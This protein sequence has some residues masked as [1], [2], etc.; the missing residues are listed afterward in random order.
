MPSRH[1]ALRS[2]L[3]LAVLSLLAEQP[4]H[5]YEMQALIRERRITDVVKLRGGSLYD[6]IKRLEAAG[7]VRPT[8]TDRAGARPERTVYAI[9]DDGTDELTSLLEE[10]LGV[11]VNEYPRFAAA[12]AHVVVLP[13]KDAVARLRGRVDQ[14]AIEVSA[15]DAGLRAAR[16]SGVGRAVLLEAEYAQAMRR[17]EASWV[18]RTAD[19]IESG[20]VPWIDIT[21]LT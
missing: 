14:L 16:K 12:L 13:A 20:A 2:P 11:P 19:D 17:A 15:V 6:A 1:R 21:D 10:F 4:R 7:L 8:A 9:T 5:P 3:T 18:R